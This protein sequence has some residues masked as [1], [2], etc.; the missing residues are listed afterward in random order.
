MN[1]KIDF[2]FSL[3]FM[4]TVS[5]D[6]KY[7]RASFSPR[8]IQKIQQ[9]N[10]ELSR[11]A[12]CTDFIVHVRGTL[13]DIF[14]PIQIEVK[15]DTVEKIPE[16]SQTFCETCVSIDPRNSKTVSKLV[17]FST[18]C[19][20][21]RCVSDLAVVGTLMNVRQ[22][23]VLGSTPTITIQYEI[24]NSGESAYLTQLKISIPSNVTQFSRVP[25]ACREESNKREMICEINAGK[26]VANSEIVK[27]A[28]NL[29]TS[30]LDGES[31]KVLA[32][33]SSAGDE[34]RPDD[35]EYENEILLT[36]FSDIE[37]IGYGRK[38]NFKTLKLFNQTFSCT[39]QA[40]LNT[41]AVH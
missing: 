36:E 8:E 14:K 22:P 15:Y 12:S 28:I 38:N 7:N 37:L 6:M 27:L 9:Y 30:K 11:E 16:Y 19:S 23:Y 2:C 24:S 39:L 40:Q 4:M 33:V 26:P 13:A 35:N 41:S 17:T 31:F 20:G 10:T 1:R 5:L 3:E 32:V 18:G 25:P 34:Q 29:E 21:D